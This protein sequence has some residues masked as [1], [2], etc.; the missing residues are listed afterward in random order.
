MKIIT[1]IIDSKNEEIVTSLLFTQGFEIAFRALSIHSLDNFISNQKDSFLVIYDLSFESN[2]KFQKKFKSDSQNR[3]IRLEPQKFNPAKILSEISS[4]KQNYLAAYIE[5]LPNVI[6]VMGSPG[7]PGVSTLVNYLGLILNGTVVSSTH[8]NLRPFGRANM[9]LISPEDLIPTLNSISNTQVLIDGGSSINLTSTMSDRRFD[10]R[11]LREV[12]GSSSHLIYVIKSNLQGI[13]YLTDFMKD[14]NNVIN[15]PVITVILNQQRFDRSSQE[16]QSSF[17]EL[18]GGLSNFVIPFTSRI[19]ANSMS[20][21]GKFSIWG[22]DSF[23]K[24][25][26]KIAAQ[27]GEKKL[28]H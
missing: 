16:I 13:N 11:W 14:F 2:L 28:Y 7:A 24:Q 20:K 12:V 1:A 4:I 21:S 6:S 18:M 27:I 26:A 15:Q 19:G 17:K 25:L 5:R 22:M 10:A 9:K 3:Y 23:Q 8:Q